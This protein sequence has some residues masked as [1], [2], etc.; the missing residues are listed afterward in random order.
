M[1][2]G[3]K[4]VKWEYSVLHGADDSPDFGEVKKIIEYM[5][6]AGDKGFELVCCHAGHFFFKRPIEAICARERAL[7]N[8]MSAQRAV[9]DNGM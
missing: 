7:M 5:N 6:K 3:W 8:M 4:G 2:E 9:D 1:I